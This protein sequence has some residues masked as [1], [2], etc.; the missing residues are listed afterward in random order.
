MASRNQQEVNRSREYWQPHRNQPFILPIRFDAQEEG[1]NAQQNTLHRT[2][3][4]MCGPNYGMAQYQEFV[5]E[6]HLDRRKFLCVGPFE[7]QS[8]RQSSEISRGLR[9]FE[10]LLGRENV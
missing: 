3:S 1:S 8:R 5:F 9:R 4:I 10:G 7:I 6:C 2:N